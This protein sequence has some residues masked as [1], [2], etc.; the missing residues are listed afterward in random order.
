MPQVQALFA[1]DPAQPMLLS[2]VSRF[3]E[4]DP[5]AAASGGA[6]NGAK[7]TSSKTRLM[8]VNSISPRFCQDNAAISFYIQVDYQKV[9]LLL[10]V[11]KNFNYR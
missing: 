11:Q 3:V 8:L 5:I 4:A 9:P 10:R 7:A 2:T 6:I 1:V